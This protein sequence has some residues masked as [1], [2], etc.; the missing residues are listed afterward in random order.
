MTWKEKVLS[1]RPGQECPLRFVG[2]DRVFIGEDEYVKS[3]KPV[4]TWF[5]LSDVEEFIGK[6]VP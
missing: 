5:G 3:P 1:V 6:A 2:P 4:H